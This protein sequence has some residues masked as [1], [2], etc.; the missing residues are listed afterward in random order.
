MM[1]G[2]YG[3]NGV[4]AILTQ[5]YNIF[6]TRETVVWKDRSGVKKRVKIHEI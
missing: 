4:E 3:V 2:Y 5:G 6:L 1:P